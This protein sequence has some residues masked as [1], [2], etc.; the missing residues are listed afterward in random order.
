MPTISLQHLVSGVLTDATSVSLSDATATYGIRLVSSGA[1]IVAPTAAITASPTGVYSYDVSALSGGVYEAVWKVEYPA[2][3]FT[4]RA[5]TFSIDAAA[6]YAGVRLMDIERALAERTGPYYELESSASS[7]TN[8]VQV[9]DIAS[10][11]DG[12]EY[13]DLYVLRRGQRTDG[14]GVVGYTSADRVR[15]VAEVNL[16]SGQ[17]VV[18]RAWTLAPVDTEVIEL[19]ALHPDREIRRAVLAGLKRCY[20]LDRLE[21]DSLGASVE[22]DLTAEASWITNPAQVR[23]VESEP[24]TATLPISMPWFRAYTRGGHVWIKLA[25]YAPL[26][27]LVTALRPAHTYVNGATSLVGPNDDDD[28]LAIDLEYA[29]AAAHI[30]LWRI[31]PARLLPG[32]AQ[33]F[34]PSRKDVAD[35]F[36]RLSM[37]RIPPAPR[38]MGFDEPFGWPAGNTIQVGG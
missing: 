36:S 32:A 24:S 33:G 5:Q 27:M 12:G 26:G 1:T 7:T 19:L 23:G 28:I 35:E 10:S 22:A 11:I 15:Q 37:T 9:L 6:P 13:S 25:G 20:F 29:T 16:A 8:L 38:R 4:Y 31:A 14:S 2:A 21:V 3:V 34:Q 18:D 30:E 17:L